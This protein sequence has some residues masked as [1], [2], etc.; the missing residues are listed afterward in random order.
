MRKFLLLLAALALA[1]PAEAIDLSSVDLLSPIGR[2]V[3]E[4]K[5]NQMPSPKVMAVDMAGKTV[6]FSDGQGQLSLP[7]MSR[8]V[9]E[10]CQLVSKGPCALLAIDEQ[11]QEFRMATVVP[12]R[13]AGKTDYD[14][15]PTLTRDLRSNEL[16]DYLA[17]GSHKALALDGFGAWGAAWGEGSP[18]QAA[19]KAVE[20]CNRAPKSRKSCFLYDLDGEI[21]PSFSKRLP[22][23]FMVQPEEGAEVGPSQCAK[24]IQFMDGKAA[25]ICQSQGVDITRLFDIVPHTGK[26]PDIRSYVSI[27]MNNKAYSLVL[28][29]KP[30]DGNTHLPYLKIDRQ[31]YMLGTNVDNGLVRADGD[32]LLLNGLVVRRM[33]RNNWPCVSYFRFGDSRQ[34]QDYSYYVVGLYCAPWQREPMSSRQ[35]LEAIEAVRIQ[36][37]GE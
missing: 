5:Y 25:D 28:L 37:D 36:E 30:A 27:V 21:A 15:I 33:A 3:A 35:I 23:P 13:V 34:E 31:A 1:C 16:G 6:A 9:L 12:M 7:E 2:D 26:L 11:L 19:D 4:A 18:D 29:L 32:A 10:R 22:F 8:I 14:T 20:S 24:Q 17:A